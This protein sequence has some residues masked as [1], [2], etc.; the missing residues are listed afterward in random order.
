[1]EEKEKSRKNTMNKTWILVAILVVITG[2]LLTVSLTAKNPIPGPTASEKMD[3]NT[4]QATLVFSDFVR[5][6]EVP[7][8][9][10]VDI[11]IDTGE[12]KM[13]LAQLEMSYEPNSLTRVD[14]KPG[15][16]IKNPRVLQ[17]SINSENGRIKYWIGTASE[18]NGIKGKGVIAIVSFAKIGTGAAQINFLPKTSITAEGLNY[19]I[20]KNMVSGYIFNLPTS[21]YQ[22]VPSASP[23]SVPQA[24]I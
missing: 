10:D 21:S 3:E 19:S 4:P 9:L 1:M 18:R 16:F 20:L 5:R 8:V 13:T 15:S 7:G 11:N 14:I 2:I 23:T 24:G 22:E 6:S 12:N 17:K